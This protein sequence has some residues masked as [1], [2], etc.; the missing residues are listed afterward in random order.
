MARY[1]VAVIKTLII[2]DIKGVIV[3]DGWIIQQPNIFKATAIS[4]MTVYDI[5]G[6]PKFIN[7]TAFFDGMQ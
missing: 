3:D 6:S 4:V 5:W 2:S 7:A 1:I